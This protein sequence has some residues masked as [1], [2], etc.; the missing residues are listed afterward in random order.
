M[1]EEVTDVEK[2][3]I[4]PHVTNPAMVELEKG[5]VWYED[6]EL[7]P[8]SEHCARELIAIAENREVEEEIERLR[9]ENSKFASTICNQRAEI[10]R[11]KRRTECKPEDVIKELAKIARLRKL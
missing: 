10:E 5:A 3:D 1:G 8:I 11:L 9:E 7:Q 4:F 6:D 2:A